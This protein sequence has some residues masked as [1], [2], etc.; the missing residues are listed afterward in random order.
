MELNHKCEQK[1]ESI[2]YSCKLH[3]IYIDASF[4][5]KVP[6]NCSSVFF[7]TLTTKKKQ[8]CFDVIVVQKLTLQFVR[9]SRKQL[10]TNLFTL[11]FELLIQNNLYYVKKHHKPF[12][13]KID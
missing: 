10:T 8:C 13:N 3:S 7:K 4:F 1:T 5:E 9:L 6:E 12:W 2:L 11:S